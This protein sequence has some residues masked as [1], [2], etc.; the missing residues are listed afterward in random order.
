MPA[1]HDLDHDPPVLD[2]LHRLVAGVDAEL[3]ADRLL[4][5]DLAAL[6]YSTGHDM[7]LVR[8]IWPVKRAAARN[9][10]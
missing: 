4:D 9:G 1:G 2:T 6:S 10:G 5:R 7:N 8:R 3:L